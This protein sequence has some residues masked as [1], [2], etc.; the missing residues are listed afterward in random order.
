MANICFNYLYIDSNREE[1]Y[2]DAVFSNKDN[3]P[4]AILEQAVI[5]AMT[6][7]IFFYAEKVGLPSLKPEGYKE[8]VDPAHHEFEAIEETKNSVSDG[9]DIGQFLIE[10]NKHKVKL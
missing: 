2:D 8:G 5:G 7:G 4:L 3:L 6:K 1:S 9:R 10:L